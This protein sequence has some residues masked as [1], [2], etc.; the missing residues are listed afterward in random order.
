MNKKNQGS[1][2]VLI[3]DDHRVLREGLVLL[4]KSKYSNYT[5]LEAGTGL[6]AVDICK[7]EF[8]SIVILDISLPDIDGLEIISSIL[9]I[10][11]DIK[12]IMLT[13]Y[14]NENFLFSAYEK[15]ARGYLLKETASDYL[16][17]AISHVHKNTGFY[18]PSYPS[19]I[20]DII[21]SDNGV[22]SALTKREIEILKLITQGKTNKNISIML[23]LSVRTVE[24]HRKNLMDK[25]N[26]KT[27]AELV[28]YSLKNGYTKI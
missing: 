1:L 7:K 21:K 2:R 22:R 19:N 28:I 25:L 5:I 16:I 3:V 27:P 24:V 26:L 9:D 15:G 8:P 13:M 14:D 18:A 4:V 23:K 12:I 20:L 11:S 10:S 17:K 6:E